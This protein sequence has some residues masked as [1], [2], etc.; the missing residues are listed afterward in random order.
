MAN[1]LHFQRIAEFILRVEGGYVSRDTADD[2]GGATKF[3]IS[4]RFARGIGLDLDGDGQV[5]EADIKLI[6]PAVFFSVIR[7]NFWEPVRA[8]DMPPPVALVL[9]DTAVHSGPSRAARLLQKAIGVKEDGRIGPITL[10]RISLAITRE[11]VVD[12]LAYRMLFLQ[13]LPNYEANKLGWSRRILHC[14]TTSTEF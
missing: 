12:F 14:A 11:L 7:E 8:A 9:T 4:L 2:P 13:G 6:T 3:G 5:S 10:N 1:N